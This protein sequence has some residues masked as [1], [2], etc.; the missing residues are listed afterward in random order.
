M[1]IHSHFIIQPIV[2]VIVVVAQR[3]DL[4][5]QIP[6]GLYIALANAVQT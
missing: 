1:L 5:H 3:K 2:A 4:T 6:L